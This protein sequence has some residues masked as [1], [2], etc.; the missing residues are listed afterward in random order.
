MVFTTSNQTTMGL[1]SKGVDRSKT[2]EVRLADFEVDTSMLHRV[3][4]MI[5]R[6]L[7]DMYGYDD[8]C[9]FK[10]ISSNTVVWT[11]NEHTFETTLL[12]NAGILH[13]INSLKLTLTLYFMSHI[14]NVLLRSVY[15]ELN[16]LTP[17][18]YDIC[19]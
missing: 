16:R 2:G 4:Y 19:P 14:G 8:I 7:Y 1:W 17:N 3:K 6:H 13:V 11:F 10:L 12:S 9:N 18:S 15:D 5:N